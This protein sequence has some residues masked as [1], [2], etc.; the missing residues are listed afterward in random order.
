M[1][2]SWIGAASA[3][4]G[5]RGDEFRRFT[6]GEVLDDPHFML[7]ELRALQRGREDDYDVLL[8]TGGAEYC[9][10]EPEEEPLEPEE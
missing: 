10:L 3:R 8:V 7:S 6:Y 9:W 5:A 4:R 1:P 2:G